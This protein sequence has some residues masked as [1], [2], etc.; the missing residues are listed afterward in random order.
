VTT[1]AEMLAISGARLAS[2][3]VEIDSKVP[4]AETVAAVCAAAGWAASPVVP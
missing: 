2:A 3:R 1:P 4:S